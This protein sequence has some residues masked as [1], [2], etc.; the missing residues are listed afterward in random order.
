MQRAF[1]YLPCIPHSRPVR[2][3]TSLPSAHAAWSDIKSIATV[4]TPKST[5]RPAFLQECAAGT[6]DGCTVAYRTFDSFAIT[7]RVDT[8][9]VKALPA[10]LRFICH[11]GAGYDQIDVAACR[12]RGIKV[13]NTPTAVDDATADIGMFLM[14]GALRNLSAAMA[15]LREGKWRGEPPPPLGHDPQGKVLGILGMGG[16]GKNMARKAKA[17]GMKIRYHNRTRLD[18]AVEKEVEAEYVDFQTLLAE[19]DVL[20]L[21]LPLN[22]SFSSCAY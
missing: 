3:L 1:F 8:E 18:A 12:A 14:L 11:N 19:S 16:I 10:S 4:Y 5:S 9:L 7:G 22:V 21:N 2:A 15:S 13:S 20:S 17:F 6:F